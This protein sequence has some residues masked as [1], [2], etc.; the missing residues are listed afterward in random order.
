MGDIAGWSEGGALGVFGS[1]HYLHF[2]GASAALSAV[3]LLV[4][5]AIERAAVC[6]VTSRHRSGGEGSE[7]NPPAFIPLHWGLRDD[8]LREQLASASSEEHCPCV[9]GAED[10]S[11]GGKGL[12]KVVACMVGLALFIIV[13]LIW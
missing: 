4:G 12:S 7:G 9:V 6:C 3:L 11:I 8:V 1:M 5:T 2:C 13:V 10:G